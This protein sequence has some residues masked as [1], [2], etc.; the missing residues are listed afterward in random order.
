MLINNIWA[1]QGAASDDSMVAPAVALAS[2]QVS[3]TVAAG[4]FAEHWQPKYNAKFK[5]VRWINVEYTAS[6]RWLTKLACRFNV[7]I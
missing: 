1:Q 3:I 6:R 7:E 4:E 5:R 2:F